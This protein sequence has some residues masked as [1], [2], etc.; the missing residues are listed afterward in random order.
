MAI[1]DDV[2]ALIIDGLITNNENDLIEC[3]D[4]TKIGVVTRKI[5]KFMSDCD[6]GYKWEQLAKAKTMFKWVVIE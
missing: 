4:N 6:L 3:A 1:H 2:V 5:A